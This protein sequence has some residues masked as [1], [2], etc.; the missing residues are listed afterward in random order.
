MSFVSGT[1]YGMRASRLRG[2]FGHVEVADEPDQGGDDPAPVGAIH[3]V[4][5][6]VGIHGMRHE[7]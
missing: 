7:R 4:D 5:S 6:R 2:L 1:V 3:R